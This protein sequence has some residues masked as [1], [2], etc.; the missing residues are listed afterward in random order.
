MKG[1]FRIVFL[2]AI[3]MSAVYVIK[4]NPK[5]VKNII[6]QIPFIN[7]HQGTVTLRFLERESQQGLAGATFEIITHNTDQPPV[8]LVTDQTGTVTTALYD[9]KEILIIT[10]KSSPSNVS[11]D[12]KVYYVEI[13]AKNVIY[14]F[15]GDVNDFVTNFTINKVGELEIIGVNLPVVEILQNP[16]LPSGCEITALTGILNYLGFTI[17][18]LV[19]TDEYF[20]QEIFTIKKGKLYGANPYTHYAGNPRNKN[21]GFYCFPPPIVEAANLYFSDIGTTMTAIDITGCEKEVILSYVKMGIP[22]LTWTTIDL[23]TPRINYSWYLN[24]TKEEYQAYVN[25]H[26]MILTGFDNDTVTVIDPL[27]GKVAYNKKTFFE[28]YEAIGKNAMIVNP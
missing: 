10:Q 27:K 4:D 28:I 1:L 21:S 7:H 25:L 2:V 5:I 22:V 12:D 24:N 14:T 26:C 6:N 9:Y 19:M 18:K 15:Y 13:N 16:E 23:E 11:M 3:S 17:D 20:P 8:T